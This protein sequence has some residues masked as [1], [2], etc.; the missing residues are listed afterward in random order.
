[1]RVQHIGYQI[2]GFYRL[3]EFGQVWAMTPKDAQHRIRIL[4]FLD[5]H[6]LAA[7][8]DAFGVSPRTLY[9]WKAALKAQGGNPTALAARSSAPKR[10]RQPETDPQLVAEIRRLRTLHPNLGKA[11]L[12]VLLASWC[13]ARG[14]SLPSV[15]TLGRIIARA[16]DKMR[17]APTRLDPRGRTRALKRRTKPR[18][19]KGVTPAPLQVIATDTIERIRDG[20]RRAIVTFIDP[21]SHFAFAWAAPS[22]HSRHTASAFESLLELLPHEPQ[23]VL[24]D[25]GSEF[26]ADFAD[27]LEH[28]GIQRWYTYPKSPRMNAHAER[29]NRTIQESFVDYHEDLLFTDL[30]AFNQKLAEWLVFYN[31]VR[32]HHSLG[33]RS[34]LSFLIQ[35][36]PECQRW[37]THTR[38]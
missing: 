3:A 37:W 1:M 20:L 38:A 23:V 29:F 25:N 32:P 24:S 31:A 14:I 9:R 36:Q 27:C 28:R 18:K 11:K 7:T 8:V 12:H 21:K 4:R 30:A 34:P 22:K 17:H 2:R 6:G 10:R 35:H 16:P 19:P 5:K 26:E 13:E 15:S 33:Q